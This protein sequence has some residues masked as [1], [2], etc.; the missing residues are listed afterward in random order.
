MF[1]GEKM[2]IDFHVH[3]KMTSRFP[4]KRDGFLLMVEEAKAGGLDALTITEHCNALKYNQGYEY[5]VKHH[6]RV[7]DCFMVNGIKVF[8][9]MEV[10]TEEGLDIL[11]IGTPEVVL[12]FRKL[13]RK[14]GNK[15]RHNLIGVE[16]LFSLGV[17][18]ELLVILAHPLR[19]HEKLIA[20]SENVINRLDAI[21]TNVSDCYTFGVKE[22]SKNIAKICAELNKPNTAG[23]DSH[24]F[25]QI[26]CAYNEL[27]KET[28][29]VSEIKK[30]VVNREFKIA[31]SN[32]LMLRVRAAKIIKKITTKRVKKEKE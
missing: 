19:K 22:N 31:F 13:V 3:G 24:Q 9:G 17:P 23:S 16:K 8:Y 14:N 15:E 30:M 7:G 5:L 20:L 2:K 29:S 12:K 1:K 4:F 6:E 18:D 21:E 27:E 32:E 11:M 25:F 26:S 28:T 10:S